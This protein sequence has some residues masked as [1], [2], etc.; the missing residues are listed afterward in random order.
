[1]AE[2]A[3]PNV[4]S[5]SLAPSRRGYGLLA[6]GGTFLFPGIGHFIVG[7]YRRG[8]IWLTVA[9]AMKI[10]SLSL[11]CNGVVLPGMALSGVAIL[12]SLCTAIDVYFAG[13]RSLRI[14]FGSAWARYGLGILLFLAGICR[15]GSE[16][17]ATFS[18]EMRH[19][20]TYM[21]S[22]KPMW[23]AVAPGDRVI[24]ASGVQPKRWD[25]VA[26]RVPS[27]QLPQHT[28]I[29]RVVGL[30]GETVEITRAGLMIDGHSVQLPL[31]VGPYAQARRGMPNNGCD[32]NPIHLGPDEYFILGDNTGISNDSRYWSDVAPGHQPGALPASYLIGVAEAVYWPAGRFKIFPR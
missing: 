31:N 23:P 24:V 18:L 30:P 6:V 12:V 2:A 3:T 11:I 21:I 15:I 14:L 5:Y 28:S 16:N 29:Q 25:I 8:I 26:F 17:W 27:P 7:F 20:H 22:T 19:M 13:R 10:I 32:G 1:L 9:I 4:L